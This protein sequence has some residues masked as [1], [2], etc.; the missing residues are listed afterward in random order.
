M[1]ERCGQ[2]SATLSDCVFPEP[3]WEPFGEHGVEEEEGEE[4]EVFCC[5]G[6]ACSHDQA[7]SSE[8]RGLRIG[9]ATVFRRGSERSFP[10]GYHP[11]D[12]RLFEAERRQNLLSRGVA[13]RK[14]KKL[15]T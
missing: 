2:S 13:V 4:Q 8:I 12:V 9:L 7:T 6:R 10:S 11:G 3:L 15:R 5:W 14:A 1:A